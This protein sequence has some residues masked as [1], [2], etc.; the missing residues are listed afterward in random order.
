[1][2]MHARIETTAFKETEEEKGNQEVAISI[3]INGKLSTKSFKVDTWIRNEQSFRCR[4]I[5]KYVELNFGN[6]VM[7]D[8]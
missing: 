2:Q 4:A 7:D 1:M 5:Y 8:E 6:L 3:V